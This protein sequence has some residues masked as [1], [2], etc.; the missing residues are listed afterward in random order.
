MNDRLPEG[1]QVRAPEKSDLERMHAVTQAYELAYY[2][3]NEFT[4]ED[5]E[6]LWNSPTFDMA[7]QARLV[8]DPTG[9][10][11]A[12]AYFDQQAYIRYSFSLDILP[13]YE[14]TSV[15]AHLMTLGEEWARRQMVKAPAEAR[16]F[17]RIWVA[18]NNRV[19]NAWYREQPAFS[20][21]RRFWEMQIELNAAPPTPLWPEGI[22]LRPFV[23]ERDARA[24]FEA[25]EEFFSDHWGHL[26][27]D[28]PTWLHWTVE[29]ADFDPALWIIACAG[30]KVAGISLCKDGAK[31]WVD[32]LGV[33]R[34]WRGKG[35]G[36]ALL[37]QSFGEF[38]RRGRL[39]VGLG[40]DAQSL[41][42]A[43]RLYERAGMHV[44]HES[45]TY[46]KELRAGVD[47]SVQVLEV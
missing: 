1:F 14:E 40:V 6:T 21:V 39:K 2:G 35:L 44:A 43:T 31:G 42:G 23:A 33:S 12:A 7:E 3:E 15:R 17:L 36:L 22:V 18:A 38:Y 9:R 16:T 8:Y 20:E 19:A 47:L 25:D 37:H 11:V 34:A 46:E 10:L 28:Y 30:E 4:L 5:M 27:Q 29:R 41:T 24:V 26:P 32:T 13:G 45:I